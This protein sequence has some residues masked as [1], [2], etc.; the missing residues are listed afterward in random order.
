MAHKPE[1]DAAF[2]VARGLR[3]M[4]RTFTRAEQVA[5]LRAR[6]KIIALRVCGFHFLEQGNA[7]EKIVQPGLLMIQ[8][9]KRVHFLFGH[10]NGNHH[11]YSAPIS[12]G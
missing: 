11:K 10:P 12:L 6:E 2:H 4:A 7:W 1:H 3:S 9:G 8:I 5:T